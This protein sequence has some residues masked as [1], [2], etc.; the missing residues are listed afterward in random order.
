MRILGE[1]VFWANDS[2]GAHLVAGLVGLRESK[3]GTGAGSFLHH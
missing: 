3:E 2:A 1:R